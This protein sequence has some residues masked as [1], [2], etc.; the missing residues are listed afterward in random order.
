[1]IEITTKS[2]LGLGL[3]LGIRV[4]V[5]VVEVVNIGKGVDQKHMGNVC[6]RSLALTHV[7]ITLVHACRS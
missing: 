6:L 3:W 2:G 1:M 4:M 5:R 7:F